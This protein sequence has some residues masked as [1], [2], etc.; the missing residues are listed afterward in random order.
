MPSGRLTVVAFG[1]ALALAVAAW[2]ARGSAAQSR[3]PLVLEP[4]GLTGEAIFP[5]FEGWGPHKDGEQVLLLGYYNRNRSQELDIP[6]GPDNRIEPGGPDHGQPTHFYTGREYGIFAIRVPKNFGT[7]KL[8]WTLTANGQTSTVSFW[9]NP[10]Y[11]LDFFKHHA[12]GNEPPTIRF[13][14]TG[15]ELTGPPR[16]MAHTLSGTVGQ[17]VPLR[18]WVSDRPQRMADVEDELAARNTRP[19]GAGLGADRVAIIGGQVIGA[20][21]STPA[22]AGPEPS[23][24]ITVTWKKY[25]GPGEVTFK[26][27]RIPALTKG[28]PGRVVDVATTATFSTPGEY[29][30]RAQVNDQSGDGGSGLQCCWTNAHV[31]VTVR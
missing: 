20:P 6:I 12:N 15:P 14:S 27:A 11:F 10:Q 4:L 22:P 19:Q 13:A 8:T 26:P 24:D 29:V 23:P 1:A 7:Q 18:A 30:V 16:G 25:R 5:A 3:P 31:K 2:D 17:P 9:L 28:D 21:Q